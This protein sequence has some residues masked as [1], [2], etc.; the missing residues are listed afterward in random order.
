MLA[1]LRSRLTPKNPSW[2]LFSKGNSVLSVEGI[3]YQRLRRVPFW[4]SSLIVGTVGIVKTDAAVGALSPAWHPEASAIN[5]QGISQLPPEP[6]IPGSSFPLPSE[7][8]PPFNPTPISPE[9]R[10]PPLEI[11]PAEPL[12]EDEQLLPTEPSLP[13]RQPTSEPPELELGTITVKQFEIVGNTV[14]AEQQLDALTAP[15]LNRAITFNEVREV[16]NAI[17]GLYREAGYVTSGAIIPRQTVDRVAGIVT[18]QVVEGS[19]EDIV[20]E[21]TRRL[22][23]SYVSRRLGLSIGPPLNREHLL[24]RLQLLQL[25]PLIDNI[26]ADLQAGTRPGQNLLVVSVTEADSFDVGYTFDNNRSP[27]VGTQRH[28]F[29]VS[30]GNLTGSGDRLAAGYTFTRGSQTVEAAYTRYINPRNGTITASFSDTNSDVIEDPFDILD[31]TSDAR[32][33]ELMLRQP[34]ITTPT[35]EFAVGLGL[36][37]QSTQTFLGIN[38]LGGFPLSAG[39]DAEG[40]TRVTALRFS[41]EWTRRNTQQVIALRSQFNV[42]LGALGATVNGGSLPDSLFFSW[43]GQGQWVRSLAPNTP[44]ILRGSLQLTPDPLLSLERYSLGGRAT[45]RGYRQDELLTDN[46]ANLALEVRLPVWQSRRNNGQLQIAPFIE[47]GIGWNT[48]EVDPSPNSL[49]GIGTSVLLEIEK[50]NLRFDYGIPLIDREDGETLQ[51]QGIYFSVGI[52]F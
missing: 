25:D 40:R 2:T 12:P 27:T 49:L 37:R 30:E 8:S 31:I 47:G 29:R 35:T 34:I 42:G 32:R 52:S 18:I 14:F 28:Q 3:F 36:S 6:V 38:D 11:T 13:N 51:E 26:S 43:L 48:E 19:V 10:L 33:L 17:N 15:Y 16:R 9:D 50:T 7:T 24:E 4:L 46:G 1:L 41:Q 22:L 23:P 44:L 5:A 20:V 39:A 21:G 45:V